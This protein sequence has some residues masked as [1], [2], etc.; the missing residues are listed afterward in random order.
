MCLTDSI[1][2]TLKIYF[3]V[4]AI[5]FSLFNLSPVETKAQVA[6]SFQAFYGDL[7]PYG[8][9]VSYSNYGYAWAP[10]VGVGFRPYYTGGHWAYTDEGWLWVSDYPWGWA[11]YH[12]GTWVMDPMYGWL[13]VPG[14]DWAPAWVSWGYYDGYYGWAP[15]APG[16][17]ISVGYRPPIDYWVFASPRYM[18]SGN[19]TR[20][21][22][23]ATN[24]R[25]S[26]GGNTITN[27]QRIS[28]VSNTSQHGG[29][30]YFAG[31]P[32]QDFE[33]NARTTVQPVALRESSKPGRTEMSG[34]AVNVYRPRVNKMEDARPAKVAK[35]ED[36]KP[37]QGRAKTV[38]QSKP[39]TA[40]GKNNPQ[41]NSK[42]NVA[43]ST[44]PPAKSQARSS[45]PNQNTQTVHQPKEMTQPSKPNRETKQVQPERS[46]AV[47]QPAPT[48]HKQSQPAPPN[49]DVSTPQSKQ[50]TYQHS[51]PQGTQRQANP[52]KQTS[53]QQQAQPMQ[54][55]GPAQAEQGRKK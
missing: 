41:M 52:H 10:S 4:T 49:R 8:T 48:Q 14:Y 54:Q 31:P 1:M 43:H 11:P 30:S 50:M 33:K 20:Y 13:W 32:R 37:V 9:W 6:V 55:Q 16:F 35:V 39:A 27:V 44:Q 46:Q 51:R 19:M 15:C 38:E 53:P 18:V 2:K 17:S 12:Y 47:H 24:H 40:S 28:T 45:S 3:V 23:P 25:I 22:Y 5:L 7:A 34:S 26:I 29:R 21:S 36:L 42:N